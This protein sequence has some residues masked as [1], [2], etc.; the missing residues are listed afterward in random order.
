MLYPYVHLP[1]AQVEAQVR[2]MTAGE[3]VAV[4]E[5][6]AGERL[7]RRHKPDGHALEPHQLP[8]R[9]PGRLWRLSRP[10]TSSHADRRMA[11]RSSP[12]T[13]TT[14]PEARSTLRA[15][16]RRST[17][18]WT[19]LP[20]C[21]TCWSTASAA[22]AAVCG[23]PCLQGALLVPTERSRGDAH[24]RTPLGPTG[25]PIAYRAVAQDMHRLIAEEAGHPAV[26]AMMTFVDHSH[27]SPRLERLDAERRAEA[28]HGS[29]E[30][31]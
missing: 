2:A 23:M 11:T 27:P 29:A 7:N 31:C 5:A 26:A 15:R 20:P 30:D 17:R 28:A 16:R 6:Y 12:D 25:T 24:D 1:E 3:R 14:R 4:V 22:Q 10:A 13:V 21:T 19:G 18:R 9:R 8:L